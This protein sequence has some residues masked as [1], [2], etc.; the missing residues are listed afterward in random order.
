MKR[1][2]NNKVFGRI[3]VCLFSMLAIIP[4]SCKKYLDAKTDKTLVIPSTLN[5]A[6]ALLD[7][8]SLMN[9]NY[10]SL[11]NES[12]D[13]Y[14]LLDSYFNGRSIKW[15]NNYTWSVDAVDETDW[16]YMYQIV[17][18]S[19]IAIETV[20]IQAD[21]LR[22]SLK[23]KSLTGAAYFFRALGFYN[24]AQYYAMPYDQATAT[25]LPGISLR[26]TSDASQVTKRATIEESWQ[27]IISDL[28]KAVSLLPETNIPLTRPSKAAAFAQLANVYLDMSEFDLAEKYADSALLLNNTL[29]DFNF[30]DQTKTFPFSRF[31]PEVAFQSV[32]QYPGSLDYTHYIVDSLLYASYDTNDLRRKLYFKNNGTGTVGF[33]GSYDGTDEP[34]NGI[35]NDEVY[36]IKAE[37]AARNGNQDIAMDYLN[38]L[39]V[40]RWITGSFIPLSVI[41]AEEALEIILTERRKELILRGRRWFDLRRLNKDPKFAKTLVRIENGIKYILPPNDNRY[42]FKIPAQVIST[43]GIE[44]NAR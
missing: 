1:N 19:N 37:C 14:Y 18:S 13:N 8:Y 32:T 5:D 43:T 17:L 44:Q 39:L 35:A 42:I 16:G 9:E 15:Q 22:R 21:S 38:R 29:M 4:V 7:F 24:I 40:T 30:I 10:P 25:K 27:Q 6:Q 31:N 12:D 3:V 28:K 20:N 2:T 23:A 41:T 36:L 33:T 11:G 34:F 26:L